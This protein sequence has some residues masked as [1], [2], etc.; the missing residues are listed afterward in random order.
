MTKHHYHFICDRCGKIIDIEVEYLDDINEIV[1]DRYRIQI[2]GH[3][4]V[5]QGICARCRE[6]D[7][8]EID[9]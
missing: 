2:Y 3:D 6:I 7:Q 4:I 1:Q 5:F 9:K 8:Q